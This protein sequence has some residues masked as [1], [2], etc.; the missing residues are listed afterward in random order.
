MTMG[1]CLSGNH[2]R[3]NGDI[4]GAK[5]DPVVVVGP[6]SVGNHLSG[7]NEGVTQESNTIHHIPSHHVRN[8]NSLPP[9]PDSD[10]NSQV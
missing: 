4:G 10:N 8:P 1:N 3:S 6:T 2:S 5:L 9:L 7:I